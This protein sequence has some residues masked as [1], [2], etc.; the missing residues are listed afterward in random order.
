[1]LNNYW[2]PTPIMWRKI[3]DSV[4]ATC[5]A[6]GTGTILEWDKVERYFTPHEIKIGLLIVFILGAGGKF[7]TNFFKKPEDETPIV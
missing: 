2:K 1:M 5:T 7:L 6:I 4:L 3:G